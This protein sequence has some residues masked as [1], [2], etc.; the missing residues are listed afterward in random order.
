MK[1]TATITLHGFCDASSKAYAAVIYMRVVDADGHTSV[2][3]VTAKTKVAPVKEITIP[4]LELCT[5]L[6]LL[7]AINNVRR[8]LQLEDA[9]Y[10]LWSDSNIVLC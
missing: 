6:L 1:P 3:L 2:S 4:R 8:V 5:A 7:T 9:G 10:T